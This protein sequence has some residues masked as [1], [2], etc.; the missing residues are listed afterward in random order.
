MF[1]KN[2]NIFART[3]MCNTFSKPVIAISSFMAPG[4]SFTSTWRVWTVD[5]ELGNYEY[6]KADDTKL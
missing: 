4:H 5:C 1:Y 6:A 3:S 2:D